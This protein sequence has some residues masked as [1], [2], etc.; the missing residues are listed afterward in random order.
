MHMLVGGVTVEDVGDGRCG[1]VTGIAVEDVGD[2]RC[3]VV[4][5]W[6]SGFALHAVCMHVHF[7]IHCHIY[8]LWCPSHSCAPTAPT[9]SSTS[10]YPM[11]HT[12]FL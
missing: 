5:G 10:T 11:L 7:S 6:A 3:D 1:V 4:S 8:F 12:M 2:G 9:V